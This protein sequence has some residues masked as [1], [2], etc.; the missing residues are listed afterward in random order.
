MGM[1]ETVFAPGLTL[2]VS[3]RAGAPSEIEVF[4]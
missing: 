2:N 3:F 1:D 4:H